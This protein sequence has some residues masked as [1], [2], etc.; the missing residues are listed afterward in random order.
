MGHISLVGSQ[1]GAGGRIRKNFTVLSRAEG[2]VRDC[3]EQ[4]TWPQEM[5]YKSQL[6]PLPCV[7][8]WA[9]HFTSQCLSFLICKMGV[10]TIQTV[11]VLREA[12]NLEISSKGLA[13]RTYL[14]PSPPTPG[15]KREMG[16]GPSP[17]TCHFF[18][19]GGGLAPHSPPSARQGGELE[20]LSPYPAASPRHSQA[21]RLPHSPLQRLLH[22]V[23]PPFSRARQRPQ[24]WSSCGTQS[25]LQPALCQRQEAG[26]SSACWGGELC[27]WTQ[28]SGGCQGLELGPA[29]SVHH[30]ERTVLEG[31]AGWLS[32]FVA[33]RLLGV[34][35]ENE[36]QK[37]GG[38]KEHSVG[39]LETQDLVRLCTNSLH[40]LHQPLPLSGLLFSRLEIVTERSVETQF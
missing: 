5:W 13:Y 17:L 35:S 37:G 25:G 40:D 29:L 3:S 31:C 34:G 2:C 12:T 7:W 21:R 16:P 19:E 6:H 38:R 26:K 18:L 24:L 30:V 23:L 14:P 20:V 28:G 4:C 15:E 9:N 10:I 33:W 22:S 39:S 27:C 1:L 11:W 8:P 36:P 32:L